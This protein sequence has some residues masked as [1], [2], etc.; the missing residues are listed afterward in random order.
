MRIYYLLFPL[1]NYTDFYWKT[2]FDMIDE[3][4]RKLSMQN[5]QPNVLLL[6]HRKTGPLYLG[7]F[8]S[9]AAKTRPF[10][11]L[12]FLAQSCLLLYRAAFS[13]KR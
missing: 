4:G 12:C 2:F 8:V 9:D 13:A 7:F 3:I 1:T 6:L 10:L 11:F 5:F